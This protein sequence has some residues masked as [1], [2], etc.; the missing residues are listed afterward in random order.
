MDI[1]VKTNDQKCKV[2]ISQRAGESSEIVLLDVD[3]IFDTI[4]I[5][6]PVS[7][8][9]QIHCVDIYS[10]FSPTVGLERNFNPNWNKRKTKSSFSSGV[11][12]HSLISHGGKNRLTYTGIFGK[13]WTTYRR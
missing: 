2:N 1:T 3:M 9:F 10:T 11:P 6:E 8:K 4:K 12:V 5:P 13:G 7:V